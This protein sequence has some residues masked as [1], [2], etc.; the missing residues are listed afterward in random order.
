MLLGIVGW[1]LGKPIKSVLV[2]NKVV[3]AGLDKPVTKKLDDGQ[4][5]EVEVVVDDFLDQKGEL[6]T[7]FLTSKVKT[8]S[9]EVKDCSF[10][11]AEVELMKHVSYIEA[12][13]ERGLPVGEVALKKIVELVRDRTEEVSRAKS[14]QVK[15]RTKPL[16]QAARKAERRLSKRH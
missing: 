14:R 13:T 3:R 9:G 2:T 8:R 10:T 5:R 4:G 16:S 11:Q 15:V 6:H 12:A 7:Q 1:V